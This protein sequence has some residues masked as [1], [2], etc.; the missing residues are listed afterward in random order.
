[1]IMRDP[2]PGNREE[3]YLLGISVGDDIKESVMEWT[4]G[5]CH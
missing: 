4:Q 1:M 5:I 3:Q 2:P